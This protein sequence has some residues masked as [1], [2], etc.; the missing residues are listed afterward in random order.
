MAGRRPLSRTEQVNMLNVA[1]KLKPRDRALITCQLLCGYRISEV[2]SLNISSV[3]RNERLVEKIGVAPRNLKGGYG[4]TRWV[5][6][7]PELSRALESYIGWLRRRLV[8]SPD[9]PLF[10]SRQTEA[11]GDLR[12]L[13]RESARLIIRAAMAKAG[14]ED[15]GR[16]GSH[17]LR[18]SFAQNV[19]KASGCDLMVL[20]TALGHSDISVTQK[21]LEVGEDA[22]VAAIRG[23]DFSRCRKPRIHAVAPFP[24]AAVPAA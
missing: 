12:S 9:M 17:S 14:V 11:N 20:K 21:Y 2:L 6:V 13:S 4:R 7:L 23:C 15:D 19:Y 22:V 16:L 1:R 5:P 10:L 18:K 8:L 3:F 24:R